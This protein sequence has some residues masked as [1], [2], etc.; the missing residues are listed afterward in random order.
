MTMNSMTGATVAVT[1]ATGYIGSHCVDQLLDAGATVHAC[2]RDPENEAKTGFLRK[3]AAAKGAADRLQLFK[4]DLLVDGSYD[5]AFDG[6][7]VA[8]HT[9][10]VVDLSGENAETTIAA[11]VNG[12]EN[13]LRSCGRSATV[14]RGVIVSSVSAILDMNKPPDHI[15]DEKDWN[16]FS[17]AENEP[18]GFAKRR[19]EEIFWSEAEA[20]GLEAVSINPA[21]VV[22]PALTASHCSGTLGPLAYLATGGGAA[23][24]KAPS[25]KVFHSKLRLV[26]VRDVAKACVKA[27]AAPAGDTSI[28][29]K[30]HL[31]ANDAPPQTWAELAP[32]YLPEYAFHVPD[33]PS[34]ADKAAETNAFYKKYIL[35]TGPMYDNSFS[36]R[37]ILKDGYI[38]MRDSLAD[39]LRSMLVYGIE[40]QKKRTE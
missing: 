13:V 23:K 16:F 33:E 26:D 34:E 2:V 32:E 31:L 21:M 38:G 7:T 24:G 11:A 40:P 6:A 14:S 10:A 28:V 35:R 17:S 8:I 25:Y 27:V 29:G 1:G 22:G 39:S 37:V 4:S 36:K 5:A 18:Y 12:T 19:S 3:L 20:A 15:F 9:A 30:R